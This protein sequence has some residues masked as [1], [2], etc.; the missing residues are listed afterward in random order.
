MEDLQKD[1]RKYERGSLPTPIELVIICWVQGLIWKSLKELYKQGLFNYLFNLWNLADLMS[2][3]SFMGWIGLRAISFAWVL[4]LQFDG[5]PEDEIWI[6]REQWHPFDPMLLSEG[7]FGAAMISSYLKLIQIFS[8]NPYLGPLQVHF[9]TIL[10]SFNTIL[11]NFQVSLGKMIIDI[12][13]FLVLYILV[14]FS[15]GCGMNNLLW[16][17]ADLEKQKCY[18]LE[19]GLPDWEVSFLE[20]FT[21]ILYKM[22]QFRNKEIHV[23]C[24]EDLPTFGK[25]HNLSFGRALVWLNWAILN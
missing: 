17:Y 25:H 12:A 23:S 21:N 9:L 10:E 2:Y 6:P 15:F 22:H 14:L 11:T 13:K 8:I 1:W 3:G 24:G 19:G 4:K 20:L 7:L 18:S 16:Y 5:L